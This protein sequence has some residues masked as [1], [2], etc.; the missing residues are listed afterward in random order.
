[1]SHLD[2]RN[3]LFCKNRDRCCD[4][5]RLT[6]EYALACSMWARADY[7]L[8][9][10]LWQNLETAM[11]YIKRLEAK[12]RELEEDLEAEV[13]LAYEERMGDDL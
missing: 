12:I 4:I 9:D 10:N 13:N 1:M 6:G 3:C 7:D 5:F 11:D 2:T 8:L